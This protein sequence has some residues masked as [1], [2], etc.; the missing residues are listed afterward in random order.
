MRVRER[1]QLTTGSLKAKPYLAN[2]AVIGDL[3]KIHDPGEGGG[4]PAQRRAAISG[5]AP[6]QGTITWRPFLSNW[7]GAGSIPAL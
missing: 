6:R 4:S 7:P 3:P 1:A 5:V 2:G